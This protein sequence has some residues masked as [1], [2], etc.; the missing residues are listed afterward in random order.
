MDSR[1]QQDYATEMNLNQYLHCIILYAILFIKIYS[2]KMVKLAITGESSDTV[3]TYSMLTRKEGVNLPVTVVMQVCC[4]S[5]QV[6]HVLT[7]QS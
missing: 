2:T 3:S 1:I 7:S 6:I 5:I 4:I